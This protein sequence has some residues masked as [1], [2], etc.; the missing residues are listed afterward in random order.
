MTIFDILFPKKCLECGRNG[1]Y[2]CEVCLAKVPKAAPPGL[3]E[4]R[5]VVRKAILALKYRFAADV[6]FELGELASQQ[7]P[8]QNTVHCLQNTILVPIPLHKKRQ[9]W[10]G[11]NQAEAIG[12]QIAKNLGWKYRND[13]LVRTEAGEPQVGLSKKE[14]VQ[15]ISGKYAVNN[16]FRSTDYSSRT[17]V[18]FDDVATTGSTLAEAARVLKKAGAK[19]VVRLTIAG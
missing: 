15:N 2:I 11:F 7:I 10:R 6:A 12:A 13:I 14:R 19:R 3:W 9:N 17:V 4:Y 5:G 16:S 18:L 8:S 1:G